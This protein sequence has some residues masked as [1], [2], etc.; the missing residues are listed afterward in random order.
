M[1]RDLLSAYLDG[2]LADHERARVERDLAAS[3][4]L[5]LELAELDAT[6]SALRSLPDLAY[7][8]AVRPQ[9]TAPTSRRPRRLGTAIAAVAAIWVV[10]LGVGVS[11]D[12]LP[13]VPD[14]D[15]LALQHAAADEGEMTMGFVP[16][17][18]KEMMD[19]DP[20]VIADIGH[21]M[22]LDSVYQADDVVQAR[23]SDGDHAVSV[24][25]ERGRVD[26]DDMPSSGK[27]EMMGETPVWRSTLD[28]VTVVVVERG[29]LVVTVVADGDMAD[30]MDD[31]MATMATTMVPPVD[32]DPSWWERL[33]AAPGNLIDRI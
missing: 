16:M 18:M 29:D 4:E 27:V 33:K 7:P 30:D 3:A 1:S 14:V 10:V 15:Q 6:R 2:E 21:G 28:G 32:D 12:S 5:R 13:I 19:E 26:W 31:D 20:A 8:R 9:T 25:H 23:Y 17:D 22:G 24:F 11:L